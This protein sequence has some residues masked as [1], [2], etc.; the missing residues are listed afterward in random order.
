MLLGNER[1]EERKT[2]ALREVDFVLVVVSAPIVPL[3][4]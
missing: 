4:E 1:E 3:S 2:I